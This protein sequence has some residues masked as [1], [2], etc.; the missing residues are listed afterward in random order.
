MDDEASETF[1]IYLNR[2][3]MVAANAKQTRDSEK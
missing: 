3:S 2:N 1:W